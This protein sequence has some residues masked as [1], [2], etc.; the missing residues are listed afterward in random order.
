MTDHSKIERLIQRIL[1]G[2]LP[3]QLDIESMQLDL[4]DLGLHGRTPL[5]VSAAEGL[6]ATAEILVRSGASVHVTGHYRTTAL[7]E[8]AA[9]GQTVIA[10]FL[11]SAGADV[12][13]ETAQGVTPLMCAAA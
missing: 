7:H 5:M 11:L 13:A 8:A 3:E 2:A 10:N 4:N 1:A 9:N 6:L 12:N